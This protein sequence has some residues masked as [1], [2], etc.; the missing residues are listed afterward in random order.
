MLPAWNRLRKIDI[1]AAEETESGYIGK[2]VP[3]RLGYV[4][5]DVQSD[6]CAAERAREGTA[7]KAGVRLFLRPDA[8]IKCGDL[9]AVYGKTPDNRITEVRR[10][11]DYAAAVAERL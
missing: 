2:T 6:I 5:A 8:G 9:A 11:R 7:E 1:Y 3:K 10:T 4:Y